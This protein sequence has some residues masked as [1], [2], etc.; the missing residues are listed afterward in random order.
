M[1][2]VCGV[3]P[4]KPRLSA[5]AGIIMTT[6]LALSC[7]VSTSVVEGSGGAEG[8]GSASAEPTSVVAIEPTAVPAQ[9]TAV[10]I[11]PTAVPVEPTAA[12]TR[13]TPVPGPPSDFVPIS[14][15]SVWWL[16]Y[17][18]PTT[19]ELVEYRVVFDSDGGFVYSAPNDLDPANEFWTADGQ[20]LTLCIN[21]CFAEYVGEW[22]DGAFRGTANN[23]QD[24]S[25]EF[26]LSPADND[27][28]PVSG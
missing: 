15:G 26:V 13:P 6:F 3:T 16:R 12:P 9:P 7:T 10:A 24:L 1:T 5:A 22:E 2:T 19:Q 8:S 28:N 27:Q 11:E 4:R 21:D 18:S 14:D 20:S 25:W 23:V 17:D